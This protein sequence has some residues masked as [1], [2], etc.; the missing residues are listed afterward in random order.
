MTH[1]LFTPYSPTEKAHS[2]NLGQEARR[3]SSCG[4]VSLTFLP[5]VQLYLQIWEVLTCVAGSAARPAWLAKASYS[6][7]SL[8]SHLLFPA[9]SFH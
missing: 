8:N 2:V 5:V 1:L 7:Q 4:C 9:L 3:F 6:H